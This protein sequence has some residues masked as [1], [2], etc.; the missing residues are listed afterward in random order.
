MNKQEI[1]DA[2]M[3]LAGGIGNDIQN[4]PLIDADMTANDLFILAAR[5]VVKQNLAGNGFQ[6]VARSFPISVAPQSLGLV[7]ELPVDVIVENLDQ[8]FLPD[9][10]FSS[11]SPTFQDFQ[12][13]KFDNLLCYWVIHNGQFITTCGADEDTPPT[14]VELYAAALPELPNNPLEEIKATPDFIDNWIYVLAMALR[15]EIRL[16]GAK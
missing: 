2:A 6:D 8:A 4:S 10:P 13:Q 16:E 5:Y 12:R 1:I 14:A 9:Y 11:Q 3:Q 15:G 7:G